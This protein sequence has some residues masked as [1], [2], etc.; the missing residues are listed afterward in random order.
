MVGRSAKSL[1]IMLK[2]TDTHREFEALARSFLAEHP[3]YSVRLRRIILQSADEVF[4]AADIL[5][6]KS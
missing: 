1:V 5:D 3:D 6:K 4:R 2:L